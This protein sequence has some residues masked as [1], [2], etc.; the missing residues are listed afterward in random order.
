MNA[1]PALGQV[2]TWRDDDVELP[3]DVLKLMLIDVAESAV[4]LHKHGW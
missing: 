3:G 2:C 4:K 1:G